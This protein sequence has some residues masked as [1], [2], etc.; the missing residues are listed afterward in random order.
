MMIR[1]VEIQA[2]DNYKIWLRY[3]DHSEGIVDL[4]YLIDRGAFKALKNKDFFESVYINEFGSIA[5]GDEIEL[6]PDAL[7]LK[8][9][10]KEIE[11]IMPGFKKYASNA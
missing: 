10:G 5:W 3:S 7:Y 1:P 4:A 6:C 11:D 9:T 2:R 8:I